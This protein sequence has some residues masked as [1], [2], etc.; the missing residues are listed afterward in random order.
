MLNVDDIYREEK[1]HLPKPSIY[2]LPI[3]IIDT[4]K[5]KDE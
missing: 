1:I 4:N 5:G 2:P 3:C